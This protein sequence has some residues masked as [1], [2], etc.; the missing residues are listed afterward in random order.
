M[1]QM[2]LGGFLVT[3]ISELARETWYVLEVSSS[4]KIYIFVYGV[5]QGDCIKKK[6]SIYIRWNQSGNRVILI[7][8]GQKPCTRII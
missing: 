5:T 7:F 1:L 4:Y 2:F 6:N 3:D 8:S